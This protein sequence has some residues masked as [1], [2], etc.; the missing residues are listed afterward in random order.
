MSLPLG[1][2]G[3][4]ER[5]GGE[6]RRSIPPKFF[7]PFYLFS[8]FS[9]PLLQFGLL[10][11]EDQTLF[12]LFLSPS[13]P[14]N[15]RMRDDKAARKPGV[16]VVELILSGLIQ[17]MDISGDGEVEEGIRRAAEAEYLRLHPSPPPPPSPRSPYRPPSRPLPRRPPSRVTTPR[18]RPLHRFGTQQLPP[19]L[20]PP[21][22]QNLSF[23]IRSLGN[24]ACC[25]CQTTE[26]THAPSPCFHMCLCEGCSRRVKKCPLCR[27]EVVTMQ[28][29]YT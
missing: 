17:E 3:G 9:L 29:I 27:S 15:P 1:G 22:P 13:P 10:P 11:R 18:H 26:K 8:P 28:R 14:S 25:V 7:N 23:L 21:R 24:K 2:V 16:S 5:R 20:P 12:F 6:G 19:P 4:G